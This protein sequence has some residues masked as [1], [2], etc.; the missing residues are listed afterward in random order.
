MLDHGGNLAEGTGWNFF[1]VRNEELHTA[2][3]RNIL[4]GVSRATTIEL[5]REMGIVVHERDLQPYDAVAADEAFLTAT[6]LCMMPVTR[7]N[8][9]PVGDGKPGPVTRRLMERWHQ[10]L[11]FDFIGHAR[12]FEDA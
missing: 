2:S 1:V 9:Q 7:F 4:A 3:E 8:G 6:S 5:A 11:A 12:R 10:Y